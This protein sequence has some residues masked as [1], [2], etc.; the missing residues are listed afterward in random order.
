MREPAG[1][2]AVLF[3]V[4]APSA[5]AARGWARLAAL[6][7]FPNDGAAGARRHA[8]PNGPAG[9]SRCGPADS[10]PWGSAAASFPNEGPA[11]RRPACVAG[12]S[13]SAP[14]CKHVIVSVA[15]APGSFC[16]R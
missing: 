10:A 11:P 12:A 9:R 1:A 15:L 13:L 8:S 7:A 2:T 14:R 6:R 16:Q 5:L 4:A 3:P